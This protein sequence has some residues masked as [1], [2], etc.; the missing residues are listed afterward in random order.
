M[1]G[2]EEALKAKTICSFC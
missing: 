2:C 1:R